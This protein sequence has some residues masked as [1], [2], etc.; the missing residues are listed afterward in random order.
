MSDASAK[1]K[2]MKSFTHIL[3]QQY[4]HYPLFIPTTFNVDWEAR[5]DRTDRKGF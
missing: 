2:Q 1:M 3:L 4:D 5:P